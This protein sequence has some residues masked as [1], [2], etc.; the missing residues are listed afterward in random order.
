MCSVK[1]NRLDKIAQD[2]AGR[3]DCETLAGVKDS[4]LTAVPAICRVLI[5]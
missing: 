3:E 2:Q 4:N 5:C 1:S